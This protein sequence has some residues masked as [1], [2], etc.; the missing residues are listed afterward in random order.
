MLNFLKIRRN[1]WR[2]MAFMTQ[3]TVNYAKQLK[4]GKNCK[5]VIITL[6]HGKSGVFLAHHF[7]E[8]ILRN[9]FADNILKGSA[10]SL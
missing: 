5:N 7:L 1:I 10:T 4:I 9:S 2:K 8:P 6:A 3:N